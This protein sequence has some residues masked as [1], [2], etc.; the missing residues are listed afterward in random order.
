PNQTPN[1][2][3]THPPAAQSKGQL[4]PS[5]QPSQSTNP[6]D[7]HPPAQTHQDAQHQQQQQ[8]P[9]PNTRQSTGGTPRAEDSCNHGEQAER[10]LPPLFVQLPRTVKVDYGPH[11]M[12]DQSE[13]T[14]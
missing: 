5:S 11:E 8:P 1:P 2:N 13:W 4:P 12:G 6:N 9:A 10:P 14:F 7:P 3:D